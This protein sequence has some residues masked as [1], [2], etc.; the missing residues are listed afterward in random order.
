M[1]DITCSQRYIPEIVN[2]H[3]SQQMTANVYVVHIL[4]AQL[5]VTTNTIG[6]YE[7]A[8]IYF[9]NLLPSS[10]PALVVGTIGC[11]DLAGLFVVGFGRINISKDL[12]ELLMGLI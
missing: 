9:I 2:R 12:T 6:G 3:K 10:L 1:A 4:Q 11:N 7:R 8:R 5:S